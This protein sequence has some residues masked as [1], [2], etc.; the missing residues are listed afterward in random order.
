MK[1]KAKCEACH[2]VKWFIRKRIYHN[3]K[4]VGN[5]TSKGELCKSCYKGILGMLEKTG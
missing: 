1:L 5:M 4:H 2:K 3:V